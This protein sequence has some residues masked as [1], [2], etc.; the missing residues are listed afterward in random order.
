M[1]TGRNATVEVVSAGLRNRRT[2]VQVL[3]DGIVT[4]RVRAWPGR[5]E[6]AHLVLTDHQTSPTVSAVRSWCELLRLEGYPLVRTGALSPEAAATFERAGF[7]RI[8]SLA[9]LRLDDPVTL[10]RLRQLPRPV[11]AMRTLR[12]TRSLHTAATIDRSAFDVDWDLDVQ[13]IRD[14]CR[15]TPAHR[16]R[17]AVTATDEPA[18][19]MITGRSGPSGFV[20]RLAVTPEHQGQGIAHALLQDGLQ[21]LAR[22][23]VKDVLV[24]T[25][26]DNVRA[27][28]L[29]AAWGFARLDDEL[30]VMERDLGTGGVE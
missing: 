16:I 6:V 12:S 23:R 2:R 4:A 9:L 21:W 22:H 7:H 29:Y 3:H 25:H 14:A 13:A 17:L 18:G 28:T 1:L 30:Q 20:Q 5:V 15:A 10:H 11:V 8:Q 24:N 26:L 19:Y 27:L